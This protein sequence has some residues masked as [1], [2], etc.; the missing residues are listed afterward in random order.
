MTKY[1]SVQEIFDMALR[2]SLATKQ[3]AIS[4]DLTS[5]SLRSGFQLAITKREMILLIKERKYDVSEA[6]INSNCLLRIHKSFID[7]DELIQ[8]VP[9]G[10]KLRRS[11][12]RSIPINDELEPVSEDTSDYG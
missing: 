8:M 7:A 6:L 12:C 3:D 2:L 1:K 9:M 11:P 4:F 5:Y 10:L